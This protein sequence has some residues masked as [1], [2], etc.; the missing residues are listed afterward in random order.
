MTTANGV[1]TSCRSPLPAQ[2][3]FC[4]TCGAKQLPVPA[5]V[6]SSERRLVTVLFADLASFTDASRDADPE[7]VIEMLNNVFARLMVECDREGGYLDKTVG[8]QL[9]VLF[10]VPKAHEDD[11][12]R[13]VRAAL[14]MQDAMNDLA[15]VML[16][17]VGTTC[18]L[19]IGI[20]TGLVVWGQV[21][22]QGRAVPTVIGDAV[23]LASR[24]QS[25][26]EGGKT[27]VSESVYLRT[28]QLFDYEALS[29][30]SVKGKPEPIPVYAPLRLRGN[31]RSTRRVMETSI[32]LTERSADV[33]TL[34]TYWARAVEGTPQIVLV[35]GDAGLG[36][37]RLL[38]EFTGT[39]RADSP[40]KK[41]QILHT[42][43]EGTSDNYYR[44]L[45]Q[46]VSMMFGLESSQT[47]ASQQRKVESLTRVLGLNAQEY[48]P[49]VRNLLGCALNGTTSA[50]SGSGTEV[51][52]QKAVD[53]VVTLLLRQ[54]TQRPVLVVVD[55]LQWA[56]ACSVNCINRVAATVQSLD[57]GLLE[58]Q[59][60]VL[61][62]SRPQG[63]SRLD[64]S[65]LAHEIRLAPLSDLGR[66]DLIYALL[67]GWGLPNSLI[68]R[69]A[70]ESG[71]NPFYLIEVIRRLVQSGQ[72]VRQD[73]AWQLTRPVH[74]LDVPATVEGLVMATLDSLEQ[75]ARRVLQ[76]ASVIGPHFS[77]ELLAAIT[78][79]GELHGILAHLEQK[80]LIVRRDGI[81]KGGG[82]AYEF[83]QRIVR[84]V[85]YNSILRKTRRQ[86]HDQIAALTEDRDRSELIGA[87]DEDDL[88]TV[89][90]HY[91]SGS[92]S[93]KIV[94][95]NLL[96]GMGD[97]NRFE[98]DEA[99]HH[100][101]LAWQA[102]GKTPDPD[103][104]TRYR[105]AEAF[106][107]A[108]TFTGDYVQARICYE[109]MKEWASGEGN[110]LAAWYRRLGRLSMRE[111]DPEAAVESYA[112]ALAAADPDDH[113]L[114]AQLDA[115]MRLL[116]D[117]V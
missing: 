37:T 111:G 46:L 25:V 78:P 110:D 57:A 50:D 23:N 80:G 5:D 42:S 12:A 17:K 97:L 39:L 75:S 117:Q 43:S 18:K 73:G 107:D 84:E 76:H 114:A 96:L 13:A 95:Y 100:L 62:A 15:A 112:E 28:R 11:P 4:P 7:D 68:D 53:A 74:Q 21:G 19:H 89:A 24:L 106:G 3:A 1:C 47:D 71:G 64:A 82:I 31:G 66:Q 61:V 83:S 85:I 94:T 86:L 91:T 33:E 49:L 8:D 93:D 65:I 79:V 99:Y 38:A 10:G 60:M 116:F 32:P 77:T 70:H 2:A 22:P 88:E 103:P 104:A 90:Y 63:A 109:Q 34:R 36:K 113:V 9:M 51:L 102:L 92:Q 44:P 41:P 101:Q 27:F 72:V 45:P 108:S 98:F 29:P 55:D 115:E 87:S 56:D 52:S 35:T 16:D 30:I 81:A 6:S 26:S 58:N 105:L 54:S 40:K 20:N 14:G 59:L 69:L 48:L 67:P